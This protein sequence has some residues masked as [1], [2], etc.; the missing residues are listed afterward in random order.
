MHTSA[1]PLGKDAVRSREKSELLSSASSLAP[2][3]HE[4]RM[5]MRTK[6]LGHDFSI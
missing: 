4:A 2:Q 3:S 1:Q 5:R 6:K